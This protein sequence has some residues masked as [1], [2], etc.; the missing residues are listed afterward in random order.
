M[1]ERQE[2]ERL[3]PNGNNYAKKG[4]TTHIESPTPRTGKQEHEPPKIRHSR[5]TQ[6]DLDI[7]GSKSSRSRRKRVRS[8]KPSVDA[9]P[10]ASTENEVQTSNI[11]MSEGHQQPPSND[12]ALDQDK[13]SLAGRFGCRD[14]VDDNPTTPDLSAQP[15]TS[16]PISNEDSGAVTPNPIH[17]RGLEGRDIPFVVSPLPQPTTDQHVP[18]SILEHNTASTGPLHTAPSPERIGENSG[19]G[20]EI[21]GEA[22]P[23]SRGIPAAEPLLD[24]DFFIF[25]EYTNLSDDDCNERPELGWLYIQGQKK[26]GFMEL[27]PY[28]FS[29][30]EPP[31]MASKPS[32][33]EVQ[34]VV[35]LRLNVRR[36][37]REIQ[38]L[39][40]LLKAKDK[41]IFAEN[42]ETFRR[43]REFV[44]ERHKHPKV[45]DSRL[46]LALRLF[47]ASR[48]S[49]D[50]CGPLNDEISSLEESLEFEEIKLTQA[51][52]SLYESFGIPPMES[53]E[54]QENGIA[55]S[56]LPIPHS[57]PISESGHNSASH[58]DEAKGENDD[59]DYSTGS[60]E[61]YRKNYHPLY[62]E[63][64]ENR[65]TQDNLY[66]RRA[67]IMKDKA[68]LED[69]QENRHRVGLTLLED[70]Q[71]YLDSLPEVLRLLDVEIDEYCV[72]IEQLRAQCLEQGII[73]EDDNYMDD[74]REDSNVY[75]DS[76]DSD[77][78]MPPPPPP[79]LP[80][81][82]PPKPPLPTPPPQ[83]NITS[84]APSS[85]PT[86]CLSIIVSNLGIRL[87]DQSYQNRINPWLFGKLAASR[88]ELTL[89]ATILSAMGAEPDIASHLD[90]LKLW[91]HDGAGAEPP[92]RPEKLDEATLNRL[93]RVTREVV[94]DGFDRA[95]VSSLFGLSLWGG[96]AYGGSDETTYLDDI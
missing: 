24:G 55:M 72:E 93:R 80:L 95:L 35:E 44:A 84:N 1:I 51:E 34:R 23:T 63:Y 57:S 78:S 67:Y 22:M 59:S 82:A 75:D 43:L 91:D 28:S 83:V 66:E 50:E 45:H 40:S 42:E 5:P 26:R 36:R 61:Q 3:G 29:S 14:H 79:P 46:E 89:L 48:S 6:L 33:T 37:R 13:L 39:K 2:H 15:T 4:A 16:G 85:M 70:D 9:G 10:M 76:D 69:Q 60:F 47:S 25:T 7:R 56:G 30:V 71:K 41:Q 53:G 68:R 90:V 8:R 62:I 64:Q 74:D 38:N 52:N 58:I 77:N 94:R 20:R 92:K 86:T 81:S 31:K 19:A 65:G 49:R 12:G 18:S 73:D 27:I 11:T 87:D 54:G 96:E 88:T 17:P 21:V 32:K